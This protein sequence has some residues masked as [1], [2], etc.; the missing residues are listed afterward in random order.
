[1][2]KFIARLF[3]VI[4]IAA[5]VAAATLWYARSE[6]QTLQK[7]QYK[8]GNPAGVETLEP[9]MIGGV[10][11]WIH[12]RG[13]NRD[14]P[15]LLYIHGGPG[16]A[17]IGST[18]RFTWAWEDYFTVVQWD[19]RQAGKSY[20]P[21]DQLAD[22]MNLEQFTNDTLEVIDYLRK[23]YNKEKIFVLGHSW[24]SYL[25]MQAVKQKPEW[26][27]AYI[28]LGQV[29]SGYD[30]E[31]ALFEHTMEQAERLNDTEALSRLKTMAPYPNADDTTEDWLAK[32]F[33]VRDILSGLTGEV[34]EH[35]KTYAETLSWFGKSTY[36][37]PELSLADLYHSIA[38]DDTL[39]GFR[40]EFERFN[41]PKE[42]GYDFDVPIFFFTG[43][44]DWQT[45]RAVS[46]RYLNEINAPYK[47]LVWFNESSHFVVTEEPG[48]FLM[49]L[50]NKVLP[51]A[52][53]GYKEDVEETAE[54]V[55]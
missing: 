55:E 52:T 53:E 17:M 49:A 25:G 50:V 40:R 36:V 4:L 11:Q 35:H 54:A 5:V 10:E 16:G 44:Y 20:Q 24:G 46:E 14:N 48:R 1:M 30:N 7:L 45:P 31:R 39:T 37:S 38:G 6:V 3:G 33:D 2:G 21:Y 13:Q 18:A 23:T 34:G 26:I 41:L 27:H 8:I 43:K 51:F 42:I 15:V 22:T 47:E 32:V 12:A 29:V 19:Q 9:V 28:G